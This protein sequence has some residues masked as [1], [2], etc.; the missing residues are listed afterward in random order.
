MSVID[1]ASKP[2]PWRSV[3]LEFVRYLEDGPKPPKHARRRKPHHKLFWTPERLQILHAGR[4][5]GKEWKVI[6][7]EMNSSI[8]ACWR[9]Y[10]E[11][12]RKSR[13]SCE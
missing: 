3:G 12:R 11:L 7:H 9:A 13:T 4:M 10:G 8:P 2:E 6:A 1:W 5:A